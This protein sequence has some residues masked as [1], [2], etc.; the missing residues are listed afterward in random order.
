[1]GVGVSL[2][3]IARNWAWGVSGSQVQVLLLIG[4][5]KGSPNRTKSWCEIQMSVT[6]QADTVSLVTTTT[7]DVLLASQLAHGLVHSSCGNR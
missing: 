3:W 5:L 7:V 2:Q 4:V 6:Q 1:M